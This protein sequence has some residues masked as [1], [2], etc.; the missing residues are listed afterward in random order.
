MS[1][2]KC[3]TTQKFNTLRADD[4]ATR[5]NIP[6]FVRNAYFI[7]KLIIINGYFK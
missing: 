4:F 6:D 3:I 7:E 2:K 5:L 1:R